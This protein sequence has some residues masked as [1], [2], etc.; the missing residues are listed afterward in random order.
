MLWLYDRNVAYVMALLRKYVSEFAPLS[1]E[2][3]KEKQLYVPR[4][5]D[6]CFRCRKRGKIFIETARKYSKF[7]RAGLAWWTFSQRTSGEGSPRVIFG[8][9]MCML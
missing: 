3:I 1:P 2:D 5:S 9:S 7:S 4:D 8:F 6:V